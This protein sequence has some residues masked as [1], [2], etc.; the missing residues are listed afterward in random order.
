MNDIYA[1]LLLI[2]YDVSESFI[3]IDSDC[4]DQVCL[5]SVAPLP[6]RPA[7]ARGT[8]QNAGKWTKFGLVIAYCQQTITER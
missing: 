4:L 1:V 2:L 3:L 7:S 8:T 5:I 6:M